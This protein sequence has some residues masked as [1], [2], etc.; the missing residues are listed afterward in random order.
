MRN[1]DLDIHRNGPDTSDLDAGWDLEGSSAPALDE[2]IDSLRPSHTTLRP[3]R[4]TPREVVA[5]LKPRIRQ[6]AA[7]MGAMFI[8]GG[9]LG[10]FATERERSRAAATQA[11][12][13]V[14]Q[15]EL[16]PPLEVAVAETADAPLPEPE[17]PPTD[18]E[19]AAA[20]SRAAARVLLQVEPAGASVFVNGQRIGSDLVHVDLEERKSERATVTLAGHRTRVVDI[21]GS[22][23]FLHVRLDA[24]P[25]PRRVKPPALVAA[26][27]SAP[28]DASEPSDGE[29]PNT[30][31]SV[32]EAEIA[33]PE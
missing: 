26:P 23:K 5:P 32:G 1:S 6:V 14:I 21:D 27:V 7:L 10:V 17:T 16:P 30:T 9:A 25:R 11:P 12:S 24:I 2:A 29:R 28:V 4:A 13:A 3:S 33:Y 31:T 15:A 22:V 19:N 20:E 18:S 8:V